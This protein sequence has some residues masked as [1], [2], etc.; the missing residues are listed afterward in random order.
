MVV[1]DY[2]DGTPAVNDGTTPAANDDAN[3]AVAVPNDNAGKSPP[4]KSAR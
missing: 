1:A 4:T 2:D 3:T